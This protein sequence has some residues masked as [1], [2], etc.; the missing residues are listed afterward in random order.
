MLEIT[1][2]RITEIY[3]EIVQTIKTGSPAQKKGL[4]KRLIVRVEIDGNVA[5]P[6]YRVPTAGVRIVETLVDPRLSEFS[7]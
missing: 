4:A 2:E 6:K 7:T 5:N 3:N 1:D